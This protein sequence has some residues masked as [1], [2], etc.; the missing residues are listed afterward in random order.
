VGGAKTT[1]GPVSTF[2]S[3]LVDDIELGKLALPKLQRP[4]DER[5]L[6]KA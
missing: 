2:L 5:F 3:Q 1:F 6:P 4:P